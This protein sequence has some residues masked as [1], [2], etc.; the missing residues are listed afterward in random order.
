M[1]N[2]SLDT[3]T[4]LRCAHP[5]RFAT[6][7]FTCLENGTI[8]KTQYDKEIIF[9][10]KEYPVSNIHDVCNVLTEI[11]KDPKQFV[12]RARPLKESGSAVHRRMHGDL[13]AFES[14]PRHWTMLDLDKIPRPVSLDPAHNPEEAVKW[15]VK[16]LPECF[17]DVTCVYQFS[18]SQ[19][20]P[21]KIGDPPPATLSLHL[22]FWC[23]RKMDEEE[24]KRYLEAWPDCPVDP[25]IFMAVQ[26]HYTAAPI[27]KGFDDPLPKRLG[28]LE[29][30]TDSVPI[31]PVPEAPRKQDQKPRSTER[32][33]ISND[34]R[35]KAVQLLVKNYPDEGDR[36]DFCAAL[37]GAMYRNGWN[38]ED[39]S[40]LVGDVADAA[41]DEEVGHREE[42]A[43]R[44]CD[45]IDNGQRAQGFTR[46]KEYIPEET[47]NEILNLLGIG[48]KKENT[49]GSIREYLFNEGARIKNYGYPEETVMDFLKSMNVNCT[50]QHHEKFSDGPLPA[51]EIEGIFKSVMKSKGTPPTAQASSLEEALEFM[52]GKYAI[53]KESGKTIVI[54]EEYDE[55]LKRIKII[56]SSFSDISKYHVEQILVGFNRTKDPIY[57]K[58]GDWWLSCTEA[59]RY[60][61]VVF[62]PLEIV[63]NAYNL[64]RGYGVEAKLGDCSLF[65]AHLRNNICRGNEEYYLWLMRWAARM[66]QD[67]G[68][69]A[70]VAI[71]MRGSRGVGKGLTVKVFGRLLG[72][73][74]LHI[75][76]SR[77]LT[78]NFN[79]H[80]QDTILLFC[81]EAFWAGDKAGEATFKSAV[82]E[83]Y[84]F[85]E[86][87]GFQGFL[88]KNM[89]HIFVAS[90]SD[91]VVPAGLD[92][93][94]FFVL[95]VGDEQQQN[96]AYFGKMMEQM[97][98]GGYE[99]LLHHLKTMPLTGFDFRN[100]PK[101]NALV[102]QKL[103][104]MDAEHK[105]LYDKL[106][107]GL[108][109]HA[110]E[111]WMPLIPKKI[112]QDDYINRCKDM[113]IPRRAAETEL[114]MMLSKMF[115]TLGTTKDMDGRPCYVF[116][117]LDECRR[118][119]EAK[120]K[121]KMPWPNEPEVF[122]PDLSGTEKT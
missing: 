106:Y 54:S 16:L 20:I 108:L 23:D 105:W 79:G 118:N 9:H 47:L 18:S 93:R 36:G 27:I 39:I 111:E 10:F 75:T 28:L 91:W 51:S 80:L 113:G 53:V 103:L 119:F 64:W 22:W 68:S 21:A 42:S 99:A 19:N 77:H 13:A 61:K 37:A 38:K 46:L 56:R 110:H 31:P 6:K 5:E 3:I 122:E 81:D 70:E 76:N 74:F 30:K 29:G 41:K 94:R 87:K 86:L 45:A 60:E 112:I 11:E 43:L 14:K 8:D 114:G 1:S 115:P 59:R 4:S 15:I 107:A 120:M 116:P 78:G 25:K 84:I 62:R 57:A 117:P 109:H 121:Q 69:A 32:P 55:A 48:R 85:I 73:H 58:A 2:S 12:I 89:L 98:N 90:N 63:K 40:G 97:E 83:E 34:N 7:T 66:I 65:L 44:I 104:S 72:Q 95:D 82:T 101:T 92:E 88:A 49:K 24:W 96:T 26:P 35:D 102:E 52:N 17:Q 33:D 67:P 50:C 71:V 100:P